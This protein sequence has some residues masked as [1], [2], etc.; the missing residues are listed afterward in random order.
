MSSKDYLIGRRSKLFFFSYHVPVTWQ[1][2]GKDEVT[3]PRSHKTWTTR[4]VDGEILRFLDPFPGVFSSLR[5]VKEA[6]SRLR[7]KL[8]PI[9]CWSSGEMA[10]DPN[11]PPMHHPPPSGGSG[12]TSQF[13]S[14]N[15]GAQPFVPSAQAPAFVPMQGYPPGY[16]GYGMQGK[17]TGS[18]V[19]VWGCDLLFRYQQH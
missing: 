2:W 12:F 3:W 10:S 18:P 19:L 17:L 9:A 1:S 11:R 5:S 4:G 8:T 14:M 15:V 7:R 6:P 13:A 16:G